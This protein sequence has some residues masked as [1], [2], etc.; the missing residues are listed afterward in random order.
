MQFKHYFLFI[1]PWCL[2]LKKI[3]HVLLFRYFY[4]ALFVYKTESITNII[5]KTFHDVCGLDMYVFE[6]IDKL[7]DGFMSFI[8]RAYLLGTYLS[9]SLPV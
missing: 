8:T 5:R 6:D 4:Q 3:G 9:E 7:G 2:K 1:V